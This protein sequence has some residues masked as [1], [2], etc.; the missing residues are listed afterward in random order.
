MLPQSLY[1]LDLSWATQSDPDV[2][3]GFLEDHGMEIGSGEDG[4]ESR[5][6][7][8]PHQIA[9]GAQ[10]V[11]I[12]AHSAAASAHIHL[13]LN[14]LGESLP[15]EDVVE[16]SRAFGAFPDKIHEMLAA[17]PDA[18]VSDLSITALVETSRNARFRM[19]QKVTLDEYTFPV[20]SITL[21]I[22]ELTPGGRLTLTA[23]L[24]RGL[25]LTFVQTHLD[26]DVTS[27]LVEEAAETAWN[28]AQK[29]LRP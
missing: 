20:E 1:K 12:H 19:P 5:A 28:I 10:W 7:V 4:W 27:T 9:A 2:M 29:F 18:T 15:P 23:P 26:F 8:L 13:D 6:F 11:A 25:R 16:A 21:D 22:S 3:R 17:W 14:R 24:K